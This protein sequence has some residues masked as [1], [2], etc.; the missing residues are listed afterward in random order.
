M[1]SA[2]RFSQSFPGFWAELLPLLTP[3]F[4]HMVNENFI[5]VVPI[6]LEVPKASEE[7][8]SAVIAECA[9]YLA[10]MASE[11]NVTAYELCLESRLLNQALREALKEVSRFEGVEAP[12]PFP[13]TKPEWE[14]VVA[15]TRNYQHFLW[16][17]SSG[18]TV[19]FHPV[20]PGA[21]FIDS[22]EADLSV[23]ESLFEVKTVNRNLAGKDMRQL[24]V[25]LALQS[26]TG[27][28]Q[29]SKAGFFNPRKAIFHEFDI[30]DLVPQMA[31]GKTAG[32]VFHE[33]ISFA[34][35]SDMPTDYAF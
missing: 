29:W 1:I 33:I 16:R 34:C 3:S 12:E 15:L 24:I 7:S 22:C 6:A 20:V 8:D 11:R 10:R 9:F 14:E 28:R 18:R 4:V 2:R 17:K 26:A 5:S 31:G 25:Y 35:Q 27:E 19:V 30:D 21:G 13:L 23:G 32:E